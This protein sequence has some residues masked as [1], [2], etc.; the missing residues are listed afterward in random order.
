MR[1]MHFIID[2]INKIWKEH[3]WEKVLW[4]EWNSCLD[5]LDT[6]YSAVV[7]TKK[8]QK[9]KEISAVSLYWMLHLTWWGNDLLGLLVVL[10]V[11]VKL[12]ETLYLTRFI[13]HCVNGHD[14]H[15]LMQQITNLIK[16]RVA[17]SFTSTY[18][19]TNNANELLSHQFICNIQYNETAE[20]SL[21]FCKQ[22]LHITYPNDPNG[23][24]IPITKPF[25]IYI[26]SIFC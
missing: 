9:D 25:S 5:H 8:L 12:V 13:I 22:L 14:S 7:C 10:Q 4:L 23:N 1:N 16:Y 11:G 2:F 3:I 26:S 15:P 24:L 21:S 17:T 19:T 6:K 20:T 18:N